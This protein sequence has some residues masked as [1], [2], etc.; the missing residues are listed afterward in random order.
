VSGEEEVWET[1]TDD[2]SLE[3]LFGEMKRR[4]EELAELDAMMD[5]GNTT[6]VADDFKEQKAWKDTSSASGTTISSPFPSPASGKPGPIAA[7]VRRHIADV[8]S[9]LTNDDARLTA[10]GCSRKTAIYDPGPYTDQPPNLPGSIKDDENDSEDGNPA[11]E[12][13]EW[14]GCPSPVPSLTTANALSAGM[15]EDVNNNFA[16]MKISSKKVNDAFSY[17]R[18]VHSDSDTICGLSEGGDDQVKL[19]TVTPRTGRRERRR[20]PAA[21]RP[22]EQRLPEIENEN[23][24]PPKSTGRRGL[25]YKLSTMRARARI[26]N[27]LRDE[28]SLEEAEGGETAPELNASASEVLPN[29]LS[30]SRF[31]YL[32]DDGVLHPKRRA[33]LGRTAL[34]D[35]FDPVREAGKW[36]GVGDE[37]IQVE[38][39]CAEIE[40]TRTIARPLVP[41]RKSSK[42]RLERPLPARMPDIKPAAFKPF[43]DNDDDI[44]PPTPP[45]PFRSA[46]IAKMKPTIPVRTSSRKKVQDSPG[47]SSTH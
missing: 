42:E 47:C 41:P 46:P 21:R 25:R 30:T 45:R 38:S 43:P 6:R 15:T 20:P 28:D 5:R 2:P 17:A 24:E 4:E 3:G 29:H 1:P 19:L 10:G 32:T 37:A 34:E 7:G 18:S 26:E 33:S 16:K 11:K 9:E 8:I 31:D 39:Q 13:G 35:A 12:V 22:S 27:W 40:G 14:L 36:Y 23:E 44:N